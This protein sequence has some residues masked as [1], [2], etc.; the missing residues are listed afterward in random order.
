MLLRKLLSTSSRNGLRFSPLN[1]L[2]VSAVML[3]IPRLFQAS[4]VS[5]GSFD[6]HN[7]SQLEQQKA[8]EEVIV[9]SSAIIVSQS[10]CLP[11]EQ[12]IKVL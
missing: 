1:Y 3:H 4:V 5:S 8:L 10:W 7:W 2:S 6:F 11:M 12:S 9:S